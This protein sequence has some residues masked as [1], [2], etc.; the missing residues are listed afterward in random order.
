MQ[1]V[2]LAAHG[3]QSSESNHPITRLL[4]GMGGIFQLKIS[5]KNTMCL[6]REFQVFDWNPFS[7]DLTRLE[8][9]PLCFKGMP[10]FS[11]EHS[12]CT[13]VV[14]W[15][16]DHST[17]F[18]LH[19]DSL[20]CVFVDTYESLTKIQQLGPMWTVVASENSRPD[21]LACF[22]AFRY[23]NVAEINCGVVVVNYC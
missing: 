10:K 21:Y 7:G 13:Y 8:G 20:T 14:I 19:E 17:N 22:E 18:D 11:V 2:A 16:S 12:C 6:F 9:S 3:I 23:P 5:L 1:G 15:W 4:G